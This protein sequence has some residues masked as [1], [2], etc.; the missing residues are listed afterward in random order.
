MKL[1]V[2]SVVSVVAIVGLV[3]CGRAA[4]NANEEGNEAFANDDF[5]TA[6]QAYERAQDEAPELAEPHY[7]SGNALYR[8]QAYQEAEDSYGQALLHAD[9]ELTRSGVF[10]LGNTFFNAQQ[11]GRAI[12]IYKEALRLDPSDLDAKHN[13]ELALGRLETQQEQA[14]DQPEESAQQLQDPDGEQEQQDPGEGEDGDRGEEEEESEDGSEQ[15]GEQQQPDPGQ[16]GQEQQDDGQLAPQPD[17]Q[18]T[19]EQARQLLE[20]VAGDTETLQ[21]R[22]Q[23]VFVAPGRPGDRDW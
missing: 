18:L 6:L 4:P 8:S 12:D 23:Q 17:S 21:E 13:L 2:W 5:E 22:L 10:N 14:E 19:E 15:P 3:A 7:N 20:A 11:Y 1:L 16:Q 9:E